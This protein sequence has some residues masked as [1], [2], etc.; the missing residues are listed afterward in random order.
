MRTEFSLKCNSRGGI[1]KHGSQRLRLK[2]FAT[3][4]PHFSSTMFAVTSLSLPTASF[5]VCTL[6]MNEN[7]HHCLFMLL[8]IYIHPYI[9]QQL[10]TFNLLTINCT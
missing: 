6:K 2:R 9:L 10:D 5:N 1:G 3:N 4:L 8:F 7:V